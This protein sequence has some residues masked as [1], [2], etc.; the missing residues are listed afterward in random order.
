M[1]DND[2]DGDPDMMTT[3]DFDKKQSKLKK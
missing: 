2:E 3:I 1:E